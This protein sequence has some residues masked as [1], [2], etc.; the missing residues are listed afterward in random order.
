MARGVSEGVVGPAGS[1]N[2]KCG[3]GHIVEEDLNRRLFFYENT[4]SGK[5][6]EFLPLQT[7]DLLCWMVV[8][9]SVITPRIN[10]LSVLLNILEVS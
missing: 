9:S 6:A 3:L 5:Y 8:Q 1:W 4:L 7:L 10:L 2:F